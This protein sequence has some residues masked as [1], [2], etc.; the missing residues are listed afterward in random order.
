MPKKKLIYCSTI[1]TSIN[2]FCRGLFCELASNYE[3]V[4]VSSPGEELDEIAQREHVRCVPIRM[5]REIA[6][7]ADVYALVHLIRFFRTEHPDAI[8]SFTPKAG[9]LCMMAAKIARVP[10]RIHTFTGLVWP[11]SEGIKRLILRTTDRLTCACASHV[12]AEG[13]GVRRDLTSG[14]ITRKQVHVLGYGNLRGIDLGYWQPENRKKTAE[15]FRL[16]YVGR[17]VPDK[18]LNE[19]VQAFLLL[20]RHHPNSTLTLVGWYEEN[21][22]LL[23]AT[24]NAIDQCDAIQYVGRQ[25]DVRPFYQETDCLVLPSYREG[26]PNVVLEAGA[27]GLPAIVTDINGSREIIQNGENGLIIPPHDA[28]RLYIAMRYMVEHPTERSRMASAA[29]PLIVARFDQRF[30]RKCLKEYYETL[31]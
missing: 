5:H 7:L 12:L 18:G 27:M 30:V 1:P 2:L 13:Q 8:H 11:T 26:F 21:T 25:A 28:N 23:P 15:T 6:P 3:V 4:V 19:L 24:L 14:G 17:L 10:I 31:F 20:L 29:R 9:L 22:P 16:I